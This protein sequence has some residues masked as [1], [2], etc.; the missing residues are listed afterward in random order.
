ML[1]STWYRATLNLPAVIG[2]I[3]E[4]VT[5]MLNLLVRQCVA[6]LIMRMVFIRMTFSHEFVDICCRGC[7]CYLVCS[8]FNL[9]SLI[10]IHCY[11]LMNFLV[12][13]QGGPK[14]VIPLVQCNI[15]SFTS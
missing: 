11:L 8:A 9:M 1:F 13:L 6:L 4:R 7:V 12:S 2:L 5:L 15:I 3:N 14:K 10:N